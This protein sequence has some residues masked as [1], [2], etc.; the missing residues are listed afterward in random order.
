MLRLIVQLSLT[1]L[2][3][4]TGL[5]GHASA[6]SIDLTALNAEVSN[7]Y[8]QGRYDEAIPIA[9]RALAIAEKLRGAE[10]TGLIT[11][12]TQLAMVYQAS[13]NY[14]EAEPLFK[15][16]L[17][18]GEKLLAPVDSNVAALVN[19]L[20]ELYRNEGRFPEAEPLYRRALAIWEKASGR[21]HPDV[22]TALNNLALLYKAQGRYREAEPLYKRALAIWEK[23]SGPNTTPTS[24][25]RS[26][27][28][29]N[30]IAPRAAMQRPSRSIGVQSTFARRRSGPVIP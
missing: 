30:S 19:N 6:H 28:S 16:A 8:Q 5:N 27:T 1:A 26:T 22:A 12:A 29:A 14:A 9:Q 2:L 15:R 21:D 17:A 24:P 7:L 11:A 18:T 25:G 13:G 3:F 23:A 4:A 10:Q 20:A